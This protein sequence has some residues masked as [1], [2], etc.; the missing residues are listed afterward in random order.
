MLKKLWLKIKKLIGSL[1]FL[2]GFIVYSLFAFIFLIFHTIRDFFTRNAHANA[3]KKTPPTSLE[4]MHMIHAELLFQI[5]QIDSQIADTK[6]EWGEENYLFIAA[7][8][9]EL[10]KQSALCQEMLH[11]KINTHF[12][13]ICNTITPSH[14]LAAV[15]PL[16][17]L[18]HQYNVSN[19]RASDPSLDFFLEVFSSDTITALHQSI[20]RRYYDQF[21][22]NITSVDDDFLFYDTSFDDYRNHP[23][24]KGVETM[25]AGL[26]FNKGL[27]EKINERIQELS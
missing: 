14:D 25:I 6:D 21:C 10:Y 11:N 7:I 8:T 26:L 1:V 22:Q 9:N 20:Y 13:T 23:L 27:L 4:F 16:L 17:Y 18:T 5:G 15:Y 24:T 2:L 12:T 3:W 19:P